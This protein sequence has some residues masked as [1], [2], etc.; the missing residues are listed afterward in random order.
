[1]RVSAPRSRFLGHVVSGYGIFVDPKKVEVIISWEPLKSVTK[2]QSFIGLAG[3]TN[4]LGMIS[5]RL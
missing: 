4:A 2:A 1:M 5:S 3:F